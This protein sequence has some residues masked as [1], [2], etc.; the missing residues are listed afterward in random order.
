[1]TRRT[2]EIFYSQAT[3]EIPDAALLAARQI[4]EL[5]REPSALDSTPEGRAAQRRV[6]LVAI[7]AAMADPSPVIGQA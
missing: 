5:S 3:Q 7:D 1:M 2:D 4:V 6:C